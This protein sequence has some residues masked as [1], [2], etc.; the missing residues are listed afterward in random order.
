MSHES[1]N[2][3]LMI[4][5]GKRKAPWTRWGYVAGLSTR[6]LMAKSSRFRFGMRLDLR[7]SQQA[8]TLGVAL[9]SHAANIACAYPLFTP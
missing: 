3:C 9:T 5:D 4:E 8:N 2:N 1:Y 7:Q 6:L